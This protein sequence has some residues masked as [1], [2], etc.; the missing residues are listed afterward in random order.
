[1]IAILIAMLLPALARALEHAR[2]VRWQGLSRNLQSDPDVCLYYNL[3][4]DRGNNVLTNMAFSS[5]AATDPARLNGMLSSPGVANTPAPTGS[6]QLAQFWA[7]DGRFHGKP[8]LT[9][10]AGATDLVLFP[11]QLSM[12]ANLLNTT[13]QISIAFW[14]AN[15]SSSNTAALFY[16]QTTQATRD[17][18]VWVPYSGTIYWAAGT[19]NGAY[20]GVS[21]TVPPSPKWQ[22]WVVTKGDGTPQQ[23]SIYENGALL[24]PINAWEGNPPQA[25][26]NET[27]Y[28]LWESNYSTA[29]PYIG[30]APGNYWT[31]VLDE[32]CMWSRALTAAEVKQMYDI[33]NPGQ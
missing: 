10:T 14:I 8:A 33:G 23:M 21:G 2:Y 9:F 15:T 6:P 26:L 25:I 13:Q 12:V 27:N 20:G 3:Q 17:I 11:S 5:P 31:G 18:G 19:L 16:W 30:A 4:N 22:Y 29:G 24:S 28:P 1:M 7:Q 32:F